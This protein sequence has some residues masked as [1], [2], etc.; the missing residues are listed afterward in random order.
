[1][2]IGSA[3]AGF[4]QPDKAKVETIKGKKYFVHIV[5]E[6]NTL[7]SIQQL[8]NTNTNIILAENEGLTSDLKLGQQILIPISTDNPKY[9]SKHAVVQG[10][11]LYGISRK[12]ACTVDDLM[13]LNPNL[14]EG[15]SP[16]QSIIVPREVSGG[17]SSE[18]IQTDPV[19]QKPA[20]LE[21]DDT[22]VNHKVLEHETLYSIA[23]RYMVSEDTI[24][25]LNDL[26]SNRLK[27]DDILKIPVKKVNKQILEKD[28]TKLTVK[29]S[30]PVVDKSEQFKEVYNVAVL[31][32]LMLD[33]N[34]MEMS[35]S[36]TVD[37]VREMYS[38]TKIAFAFYQG[39]LM[40]AD[41]LAKA[42]L[43][44]NIYI[45]DTRRDT[46]TI[47]TIFEKNEFM[48]MD[49]VVGP[50][51]PNT[52]NFTS[53]I[54]AQRKIKIVLPFNSDA[55]VLYQNP[56]V[57]KGV[58][59]NMTLMDGAVDYIL[60]NHKQHNIILIKPT[61]AVDLALYEHVRQRFNEKMAGLSGKYNVTVIESGM[62]GIGGKELN[63]LMR[64][65]TANIVVIPSISTTFVSGAMSRLNK[66]L[67]MNSYAKKMKIIAFGLEEWNKFE[68]LDLEYRNRANQHYASYRFMD[69]DTEE[70]V[71]FIRAFRGAYGTDPNVYA[72]QGFDYG[73]YFLSALHL[74]GTNFDMSIADHHMDLTQN[75]FNFRVVQS[76]SGRENQQV[77]IVKY[78]NYHLVE[79]K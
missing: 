7:Y 11:T 67:N 26:K 30:V 68:D 72:C 10:E 61:S 66:V 43:N 60:A 45:Y 34:D 46:A 48:D 71:R 18:V 16:G 52:I 9:Y 69:Y 64:K 29:D 5:E 39:F 32:P 25:A 2:L 21:L 49:L 47:A 59:S 17:Q 3:F 24:I 56:Y 51:Y 55:D 19:E 12:Y 38:T 36:V 31:L 22:I 15:I 74:Y 6:G 8:Y 42:G 77:C 23:K 35:K 79:M 33:K 70:S 37:Q 28:L 62:G 40:A 58:P 63:A 1:L 75:N 57:Y 73:M 54:C 20:R 65:D 14:S 44:V 76:G 4:S 50:L 27:K 78:D 41:S 13:V 53:K